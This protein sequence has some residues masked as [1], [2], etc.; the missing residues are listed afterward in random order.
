LS[1]LELLELSEQRPRLVHLTFV[2]ELRF[3]NPYADIRFTANRLPHWQQE[4]AAYFITFR[5][6]DAVPH[7]L[8]T[9]WE[10]EREAWLRVHPQPWS[11]EVERDYHEQF[12]AAIERWLDAGHGSCILRRPDCAGVVSEA[13]S[14]FDGDRVAMI[15]FVVM[16]NHVHVLFV[17]NPNWPLEKLLRSWKSFASRKINS[18]L[19]RE[20]SG[21]QRDY[22]DRLVRD[23]KHFANCVRYIRR[24]PAKAHL[25]NG[26]YI[27]YE[28]EPARTIDES[29]PFS[30]TA[31]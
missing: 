6:A 2:A 16:P 24:N 20:G 23:E 4:G 9:Q 22:F 1:Q 14:Y 28:S 11:T 27:L 7:H 29:H 8:R 10:S 18:L 17:Q 31:D 15:S 21:W 13:L 25:Q 26:E 12:S 3:F 19:S 30:Q 5:L